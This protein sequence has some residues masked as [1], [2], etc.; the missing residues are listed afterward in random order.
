MPNFRPNLKKKSEIH[1]GSKYYGNQHQLEYD[2]IFSPG[3]D[4]RAI[5]WDVAGAESLSINSQGALVMKAEGGE[6]RLERPVAYQKK[7]G[8][9]QSVPVKYVLAGKHSVRLEVGSYDRAQTLVVDPVLSYSTYV[10]GGSIDGA[11]AIA[12]AS[13]N[14]A[15]IA[16]QT[17]SVDFPAAHSLNSYSGSGDAFATKLS[18]D[19]STVLYSTYLGGARTDVA[20]GIAVDNLG[21]AYVVGWTLSDDFPVTPGSIDPEC[22]GDG[23][24]GATF[25]STGLIVSNG[26]ITKLNTEGSSLL[27]STY[28]GDYEHVRIQAVAVDSNQIA[29]LTGQT[30]AALPF[31]A[32]T[33][34]FT[35]GVESTVTKVTFFPFPTNTSI[36]TTNPVPGSPGYFGGDTDAFVTAISATGSTILYSSYLGGSGEDVG[37]GIAT[38]G[39]GNA[40]VTGLTYSSDFAAS[41]TT[42]S[43]QAAYGGAGDAFVAKV[44]TNLAGTV[45]PA[46]LLYSSYLGG[47]EL[48]QGNGVA[49]DQSGNMYV[50]G[51]ANS[52]TLTVTPSTARPYAGLGDAFVAKFNPAASGVASLDYF[53]YLGGSLADSAFGIAVDSNGDA[54]VTGSTVSK[55]FPTTA[56]VFQPAY[57]GG[58]ADAFVT[59]LGPTGATMVYSTFLGGTNTDIG[60]GIGVDSGGSAYVAG[61]TCSLDFPLSNPEQSA[62][63]GNCDAFV[64]K[65]TIQTGI[66]LN[67]AGLVFAPQSLGTTSTSQSV[68]LTNGENPVTITNIAV[69]GTDPGDFKETNTCGNSLAPGQ[70]CAISVTFTPSAIGTRTASVALTDSAVGSPQLISLT[71]TTSTLTLSSSTL[72]FGNV[73]EN[74]ASSP[75]T[76]T[77]TNSGATPISISSI[78]VSGDFSE[79]D[80]CTKVALQ[81]TTN[82]VIEVTFTPI[83]VGSSI[84]ALTLNDDAAGSPQIVLLSGTGVGT[85]STLSFSATTLSFGNQAV[86][87]ASAP[88]AVTVTNIGNT[89]VAVSSITASGDF[90]ETDDCVKVPLQPN[91]NCT[92]NVTFTAQAVGGSTGAILVTDNAAGS[93]QVLLANGTGTSSAPDFAVSV[94]QP[95]ASVPAGQSAAY[96][97]MVSSLFGFSQPVQLACSGL[98]AGAN[99]GATPNPVTPIAA[100]APVTL[101]IST[102]LRAAV[103]PQLKW[104]NGPGSWRIGPGLVSLGI[105]LA[106]EAI[107]L[108]AGKSL[109]RRRAVATLGLAIAMGLALIGCST[110]GSSANTPAGTPAGTYQVT[111]TGTSGTVT[112][113]VTVSLQVK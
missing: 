104:L 18:A 55:D 1:A 40:Y 54:Y 57:G 74:V 30:T 97:L 62:P 61:Q 33:E 95:S 28:L 83:T 41:A 102:A 36:N 17:F 76:I 67:P 72:S 89:V 96:G 48:D 4:P 70:T 60:Y 7:N 27:Y 37:L 34:V 3:A 106:L 92:I 98:P 14:T 42:T 26:F 75:I 111:V 52:S 87:A 11:N 22:G 80:D 32:T 93:P 31:I 35:N 73:N 6:V 78:T 100:G 65:V 107:Y 109:P 10:G 56:G 15:F 103:P 12:V 108:A 47:A 9:E 51:L 38:D 25:N 13:D 91:T 101:L 85:S 77:A 23:K 44:N 71:G 99:C 8:Q 46:S 63:G 84:G 59:E 105:L 90:S 86:G 50:A 2:V 43:F 29:Y 16:G 58:N 69:Q 20:T 82:C 21:N 39:A 81:P 19:G 45:G 79:T 24:C 5:R 64:S 94:I 68:T 113:S 110:G 66:A 49:V 88:I 112:H 53:T